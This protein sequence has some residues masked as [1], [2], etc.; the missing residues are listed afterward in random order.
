VTLPGVLLLRGGG[1]RSELVYALT[2]LENIVHGAK[3]SLIGK[4]QERR[5]WEKD[6]SGLTGNKKTWGQTPFIEVL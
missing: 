2:L 4:K 5:E 3:E 1:D 6:V